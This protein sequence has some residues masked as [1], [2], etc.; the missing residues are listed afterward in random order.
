MK[1]AGLSLQ[2]ARGRGGTKSKS[3]V[4]KM[5]IYRSSNYVCIKRD[6]DAVKKG[7]FIWTQ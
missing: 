6:N 7:K 4:D 2:V 1:H 5:S 3:I